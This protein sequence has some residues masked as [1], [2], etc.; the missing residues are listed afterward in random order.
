MRES[1]LGCEGRYVKRGEGR[2]GEV[3]WD[4]RGGEDRWVE[5]WGGVR[6]CV[7]V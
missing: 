1:V 5:V 4:V 3:C 2:C 7:G 6:E